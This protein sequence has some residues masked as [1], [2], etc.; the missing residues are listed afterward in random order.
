MIPWAKIEIKRTIEKKNKEK[1][2]KQNGEVYL[3]SQ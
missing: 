2:R 1:K 3:L